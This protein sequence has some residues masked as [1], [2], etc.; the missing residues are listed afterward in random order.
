M[1]SIRSFG[2]KC[3]L[4]T[5]FFLLS[6]LLLLLNECKNLQIVKYIFFPHPTIFNEFSM[7]IVNIAKLS[8]FFFAVHEALKFTKTFGVVGRHEPKKMRVPNTF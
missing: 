4:Y 5:Y 7:N 1:I 3:I 6:L 2:I 8:G